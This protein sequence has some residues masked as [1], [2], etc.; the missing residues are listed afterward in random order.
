MCASL[1]AGLRQ[2]QDG[3]QQQLEPLRQ[4]HPGQLQGERPGARVSGDYVMC[5]R[6]EIS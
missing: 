1:P 6:V 4:V 3:A 2:L 5:M